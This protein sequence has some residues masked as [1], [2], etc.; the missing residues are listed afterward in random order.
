VKRALRGGVVALLATGAALVVA[1]L[2]FRAFGPAPP[3]LPRL[4]GEDG[5]V[6]DLGQVIGFFRDGAARDPDDPRNG[7]KPGFHARLC[8][9]SPALPYFDDDGCVDVSINSLG[10]RDEEFPLAKPAGEYRVLAIG[11]SFTFAQGC[12]AEDGWT[13]VLEERLAA[14]LGRPVQVMNAGFTGGGSWPQEYAP[15]VIAHAL[16]YQPDRV[17]YG[18]CLNDMNRRVPMLAYVKVWGDEAPDEGWG[19]WLGG[20]SHLLNHLQRERR[21]KAMLSVAPPDMTRIIEVD[22]GPWQAN[23]AAIRAMSEHLD[24]AGVPFTVAVFPM[25]SGLGADYPYAGLHAAVAELCASAGIDTVDLLAPFRGLD[26]MSLWVHPFDQHPNPTAH[27][28]FADGIFAHL[29]E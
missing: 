7:I 27:R 6:V 28:M 11:D 19:R 25:L 10:F 22:P 24:A 23:Q 8:Y 2:G 26:D 12:R 29:R 1:E 13:E 15:W 5:E 4:I 9:D 3:K 20:A 16:K 17:V 18:M 21:Q 14:E